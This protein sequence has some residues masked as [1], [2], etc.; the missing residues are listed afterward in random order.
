MQQKTQVAVR[1][2]SIPMGMTPE[3]KQEFADQLEG[4]KA[5]RHPGIVRCYGGGFDAKDAYL[6][7]ELFDGESLGSALSRKERLP[8]E[9][10]LDM[11]LQLCE[12]LQVAHDAGWVHGRIRPDKVLISRDGSKFKL[13]DFRRGPGSPAPMTTE[14]LSYCAPETMA[15]RPRTDAA[16][17]LYSIGAVL[18][19][20]LTGHAPFQAGNPGMMKQAI[21]EVPI[22]PVATIVFDCPVWLSS[23]V[24]QL[25]HKDP[26]RRPYTATATSMALRE[27]Q[28]RATEG[29][30]VAEH[31]LSGFSPLQLNTTREEAERA[32]GQKKK[33]KRRSLV[34]DEGD[35]PGLLERPWVLFALLICTV[36]L[37]TYLVW[38]PGERTLRA[39]AER[40]ISAG[41]LVSLNDAR[42]KYLIDLV[43]RFPNGSHAA[44]AQEQLDIIEMENAE[45]S[46]QRKRRF[47]RE[48]A[49]EGERK[50]MEANRFELFGDRVTALEQY[51]AIV[52]L[53][54]DEEK[55]RVY[56]NLA[57][58][59]IARIQSNPPNAEELR[60]FLKSKLDEADKLYSGGDAIGAK[61]IWEGIVNLYNGNKEMMPIVEQAQS[62][63][64][65]MKG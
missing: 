32:L 15:D 2:F 3:A 52:N 36:A 13:N 14:Q 44:W 63:L 39:R 38:P 21:R 33:K 29:I 17:D 8:W 47:G 43:E 60:R 42:D 24:E 27:A 62:R 35:A 11:G 57:R 64:S 58:R 7:H 25:M 61:Q 22:A 23:I 9:S 5:L 51:R 40:L 20:S 37:I 50:F 49:S 10:V 12:A 55:E 53:L 54:K 19:R 56:V 45:E 30:S 16:S 6:V 4:L 48:P 46:I 28:K 59:Q 1:V 31:T 26:L 34:D 65:K 18:Y 41:D